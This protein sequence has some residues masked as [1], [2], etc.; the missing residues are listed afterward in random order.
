MRGKQ[1]GAKPAPA[2]QRNIPAYAGKTQTMPCTSPQHPEHPRVCGENL[3]LIA[4]S[5]GPAGTSPRMRGKR[6]PRQSWVWSVRNIPAYAGKTAQAAQ[7]ARVAAEHPRV[8]G[9]NFTMKP[10]D[11][12]LQ[13]TSPRMRGKPLFQYGCAQCGRNIPA[14][15]GKTFSPRIKAIFSPEHPRVC[16]ENYW[17]TATSKPHGEHPRVCGENRRAR[18]K[19]LAAEGTSP[20]MRG[21]PL[22]LADPNSK[23]RNIPAYAGKTAAGQQERAKAAEHPRVCGENQ[24]I[25]NKIDGAKGTSPRMRGK[26]G[27]GQATLWG[28]RN[29]PAYA[30]KTRNPR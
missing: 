21:K 23:A 9:E 2:V 20:R 7:A 25:P 11:F 17:L 19:L 6:W 4:H 27:P 26:L 18:Q 1:M 29:I 12:F 8:C 15:A 22:L 5:L 24:F 30:G 3:D 28:D 13:G 10:R 14:Y 16:G